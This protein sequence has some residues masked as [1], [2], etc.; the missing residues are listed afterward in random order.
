MS[1]YLREGYPTAY[2]SFFIVS[3]TEI[4]TQFASISFA[5]YIVGGTKYS[6]MKAYSCVIIFLTAVMATGVRGE[7]YL[8]AAEISNN[9][10]NIDADM[11]SFNYH[12]PLGSYRTFRNSN[13]DIDMSA[14]EERATAVAMQA[15]VPSNSLTN[16]IICG[17]QGW[18]AYP[19]M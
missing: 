3:L 15:V 4:I 8:R 13:D 11:M 9:E 5:S 12:Q 19:G 14:K 1:W 17:Y 18:Y 16:Q 6:T 2:Q 10:E 7:R